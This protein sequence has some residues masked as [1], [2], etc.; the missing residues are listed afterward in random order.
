LARE[1]EELHRIID[2]VTS[3][4][5]TVRQQYGNDLKQ[6]LTALQALEYTPI[7]E[8][9]TFNQ[10]YLASAIS[11]ARDDVQNEISLLHKVFERDDSCVIWL[12]QG[13]LWPAITP[14]T[15]LENLRSISKCVFGDGMMEKLMSFALSITALQRLVRL[16]DALQKSHSQKVTEELQNVGHSNWEPQDYPDWV[17]LEIEANM[18]IRPTQVEV[19]LATVSPSSESNAVCQLNMGQGKTSCVIPMAATILADGKNLHRVVVTKHLML[20]TAQLLHARLGGI[21]GRQITHVPFS[22]KT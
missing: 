19:T 7:S 21:C 22:G 20:Q 9:S 16:Q 15:L 18:L 1:V 17:L 12:Q 10:A 2:G 5:S 3:S 11:K 6:S 8:E 13:G 4:N 14:V